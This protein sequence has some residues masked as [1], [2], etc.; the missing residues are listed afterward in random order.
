MSQLRIILVVYH[1]PDTKAEKQ[2]NF[3]CSNDGR[4][5]LLDVKTVFGVKALAKCDENGTIEYVFASDK[6][7]YSITK[8]FQSE[9]VGIGVPVSTGVLHVT[10][11]KKF[12]RNRH[13]LTVTD[14]PLLLSEAFYSLSKEEIK[15]AYR[16]CGLI[17]GTDEYYDRH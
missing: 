15:N 11:V 13:P 9:T 17:Y 14:I 4:L 16:K 1:D 3:Q 2:Q 7:G 5:S 8:F 6:Y 12:I 10:G